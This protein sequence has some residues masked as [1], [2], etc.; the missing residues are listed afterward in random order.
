MTEDEK[1]VRYR[2]EQG[3]PAPHLTDAER[4]DRILAD[5]RPSGNKKF[6]CYEFADDGSC[7]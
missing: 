7:T 6:P 4:S 5:P 2:R 1:E 3:I